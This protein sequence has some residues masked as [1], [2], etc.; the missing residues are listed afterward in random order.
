MKN[1]FFMVVD[2]IEMKRNHRLVTYQVGRWSHI[3]RNDFS[4]WE[5]QTHDDQ[6]FGV[7]G[8]DH[9]QKGVAVKKKCVS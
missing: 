5:G 3:C 8:A 1:M 4:H 9:C 2:F 7:Q 6:Y